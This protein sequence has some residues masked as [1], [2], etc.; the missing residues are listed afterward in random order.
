[1][2]KKRHQ[3][4]SIALSP[5]DVKRLQVLLRQEGSPLG[6]IEWPEALQ[7]GLRQ[8]FELLATGQNLV[9]LP[10]HQELTTQEAAELLN[11]SR[12][13]L[14]KLLDQEHIPYVAVGSH[15]RIRLEDLL[16]YQSRREGEKHSNDWEARARQF[17]EEGKVVTYVADL[18]NSRAL[19]VSP[20]LETLTGYTPEEWLEDPELFHRLIHPED[21]ARV[22]QAERAM[23]ERNE[24]LQVQYR[25]RSRSGQVR[26][27]HC[28][29]FVKTSDDGKSRL[30]HGSVFDI[31]KQREV[32]EA[33][34]RRLALE[35]LI[36]GIST[37]FINVSPEAID[38]EFVRAMQL[39]GSFMEIERVYIYQFN[40][41]AS[42]IS[43]THEWHENGL[44]DMRHE[45][46][47]L[48]I[49]EYAWWV[50]RIMNLEPVDVPKVRSLPPQEEP[51][52][53]YLLSKG[54]RSLLM[55][56][57]VVDGKATGALGFSW[58]KEEKVLQAEDLPFF[59]VIADFFTTSLRRKQ[60]Q[61]KIR[62]SLER[63]RSVSQHSRSWLWEIDPQGNYTFYTQGIEE[64]LG[65]SSH[66]FLTRNALD[67]IAEEEERERF[68]HLL[69]K[70]KPL[71]DYI[72]A[73]LKKDGDVLWVILNGMPFFTEDGRFAGYRGVSTD[74]TELH[75]TQVELAKA[76][77]KLE[78]LLTKS[79][80]ILYSCEPFGDYPTT[81]VSENVRLLGYEPK[82][83]IEDPELW[84][85]L[86]H[87]EDAPSLFF[88]RRELFNR[89]SFSANYR[90]R[91]HDGSYRWLHDESILVKEGEKPL[92]ITGYWLDVTERR[93]LEESTLRTE[94]RLMHFLAT[95]PAVLYTCEPFGDY[96][97]TSI[98]E[99]VFA[100]LGYRASEF[101]EKPSFWSQLV[102]PEDAPTLFFEL[103]KLF[104]EGTI[105]LEYR[106]RHQNGAYRWVRAEASL[107]KEGGRPVEIIGSWV[108]ISEQKRLEAEINSAKE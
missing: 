69:S 30:L 33:L 105:R 86:I 101:L 72:Q 28:E 104:E 76:R 14:V 73:R 52:K 2:S 4:I 1:M 87:P 81:F 17:F 51:I 5:K 63:L 89:G 107:V 49:S 54:V 96:P 3:P 80:I 21:L 95:C 85:R 59:K 22:E 16:A 15:R 53:H 10:Q 67:F 106:L 12:P 50:D 24:P 13:F 61:E 93:E 48:P 91:H 64:V 75:R 23:I 9:L 94:Q 77:N 19:Y 37:R 27:L 11:V 8:A 42:L 32:E 46:Q 83:F 45:R 102:H 38:Q 71:H 39:L 99:N 65:Y 82:D 7:Q 35:E 92:E 108:D 18:T 103:R 25:I 79:P 66:E 90:F 58:L 26:W 68:R 78:H 20:Q 43:M 6:K 56:P 44:P 29:G 41:D 47:N 84:G 40:E 31:S 70:Q 55:L 98:S 62:Q 88:A 74:I 36:A 57:L 97:T 100:M 34:L 60:D